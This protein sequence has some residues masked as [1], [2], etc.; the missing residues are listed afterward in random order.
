MEELELIKSLDKVSNVDVALLPQVKDDA[1]NSKVGFFSVQIPDSL[2]F[3]GTAVK[4]PDKIFYYA[5]ARKAFLPVTREIYLSAKED[6][7][8]EIGSLE[9]FVNH[10]LEFFIDAVKPAIKFAVDELVK[11][12]VYEID[13]EDFF[14]KY[15]IGD[16]FKRIYDIHQQMTN[17]YNALRKKQADKDAYRKAKRDYEA[18]AYGKSG[19]EQFLSFS[20]DMVMKGANEIGNSIKESGIFSEDKKEKLLSE[21]NYIFDKIIDDFAMA[22]QDATGMDL[23]NPVS[24]EDAKKADNILKHI[25]SGAVPDDKQEQAALAAFK[26]NPFSSEL[27][28]WCINKYYDKDGNFQVIAQYLSMEEVINKAKQMIL[29]EQTKNIGTLAEAKQ[30]KEKIEFLEKELSFSDQEVVKVVDEAIGKLETYNSSNHTALEKKKEDN[31][32]S[33]DNMLLKESCPPSAEK[34]TEEAVSLNEGIVKSVLPSEKSDKDK[35]VALVL[36]LIFGGLGV[37]Y[38]YVGKKAT[39]IIMLLCTLVG[40]ALIVPLIFVA[41]WLVVDLFNIILCKFTDSNGR[42]LM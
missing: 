35:W 5:A 37:H 21:L 9:D 10:G 12:G 41:L 38:F 33:N 7:D 34:K 24:K 36:L 20:A 26:L 6:F 30:S 22:L 3:H 11:H 18:V 16:D 2:K 29:L 19:W 23:N 28:V 25:L 4:F 14:E 8:L 42:Y 39:G 31:V 40:L 27:L 15:V 32:F 13:E 1:G 17:E